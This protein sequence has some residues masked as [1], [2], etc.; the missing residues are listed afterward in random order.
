[1]LLGL[2]LQ[3]ASITKLS[4]V[5]RNKHRPYQSSTVAVRPLAWIPPLIG[6]LRAMHEMLASRIDMLQE[7]SLLQQGSFTKNPPPPPPPPPP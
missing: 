3:V 7:F 2:A 4:H 5:R 1:M 6:R